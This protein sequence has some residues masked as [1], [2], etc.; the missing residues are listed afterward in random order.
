M[1][2]KISQEF[3]QKA[4]ML[5]IHG[6]SPE[7]IERKID[8]A[9]SSVRN[10]IAELKR[11]EYPEYDSFLSELDDM[12]SLSRLMRSKNRSVQEAITGVIIFEG[13]VEIGVEPSELREYL[14]LFKRVTPS[15]FPVEKFARAALRLMKLE[16]ESGLRF[17]ELEAKV[18]QLISTIAKLEA[19]EKE[20][21]ANIMGLDSRAKETREKFERSLAENETRLARENESFES[22]IAQLRQKKEA[23]LSNNRVTEKNIDRYLAMQTRLASK[24]IHI[25][26]AGVI[27][28][29]IDELAKYGWKAD[30]IISYLQEVKDLSQEVKQVEGQLTDVQKELSA[31]K[32]ALSETRT[33]FEE[34]KSQLAKLRLLATE[35]R[36]NLAQTV[37]KIGQNNLRVDLGD[38]LVALFDETSRVKDVQ[39]LQMARTL[40]TIVQ[41]R[42]DRQNLL[43]DYGALRERLLLLMETVLG[44]R[45]VTREL[46][47][48][49]TKRQNDLVFDLQ[50]DRLGKLERVREEQRE[51][52]ARLQNERTELALNK[53]AFASFTGDTIL[54]L[55]ANRTGKKEVHIVFC[56]KCHYRQAYQLGT[57]PYNGPE[58]CPCCQGNLRTR[59]IAGIKATA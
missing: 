40:E 41:T 10:I 7:V 32:K 13:L 9:S 14:Q 57:R 21:Q 15:D 58:W 3:R 2:T 51:E 18:P 42:K 48:E 30:R 37:E 54:A 1:P 27:E 52:R 25:E 29:I 45:L 50:L 44:K 39:L 47:E 6:D 43:V 16:S 34:E 31:T 5:W 49:Q 19:K 17:P 26:R 33:T 24:G 22:E 46:M 55:A 8:I 23:Q 20:L 38:T 11:G 36:Q 12:R 56:V 4:I 35:Y 59:S 53:T 28:G